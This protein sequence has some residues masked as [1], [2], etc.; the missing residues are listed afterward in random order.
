MKFKLGL[1]LTYMDSLCSHLSSFP[2]LSLIN[3]PLKGICFNHTDLCVF[4][5]SLLSML[6]YLCKKNSMNLSL[7]MSLISNKI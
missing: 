4:V 6:K 2:K 7:I 3:I 1:G 5:F